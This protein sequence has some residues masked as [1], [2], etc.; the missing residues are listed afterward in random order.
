MD[1]FWWFLLGTILIVVGI[2][3]GIA[4][5]VWKFPSASSQ[6]Y[7]WGK[8]VCVTTKGW[9]TYNDHITCMEVKK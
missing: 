7:G 8:Q 9:N 3:A 6:S 4:F 5:A 2:G 1:D